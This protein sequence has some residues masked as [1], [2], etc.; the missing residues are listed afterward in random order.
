MLKNLEA[1]PESV[2]STI[3]DYFSKFIN[4]FPD[5][6]DSIYLYG[7]VITEDFRPEQ[8][9]VNSMV[10]F[11]SFESK[12]IGALRSVVRGGLKKRI[13]A[14]LCLSVETFRR[15]ADVFPLEFIE[16]KDKHLCLY[17]DCDHVNE[18]D[19]PREHLRAKIEE[20]IKGKLIRLRQVYME[21]QGLDRELADVLVE[22]QRQL[23]PV[24]RNLLRFLGMDSPP[25][26]KD[27]ILSKLESRTQFALLPCR[28]VW[29][30]MTGR[31]SIKSRTLA[32]YNDYIDVL[33][34][35]A[36]VIDRME[37]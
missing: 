22:A 14:P 30:H 37:A 16:I 8:S 1:V 7:S 27:E 9:D 20:Q 21:H 31:A 2:R 4:I 19:I 28:Q 26:S 35:L 34:K 3:K 29:E 32:V 18:L 13:I 25:V 5:K 15:S 12:E 33:L 24:F 10:L 17:G 36:Q 6:I 23:F 11:D